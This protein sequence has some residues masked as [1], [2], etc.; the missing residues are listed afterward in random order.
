MHAKL[1]R[2]HRS[3]LRVWDAI[4]Q[5][6][7]VPFRYYGIYDGLDLRQVPWRRGQGYD[8]G[9]LTNVYTANH[10]WVGQLIAQVYERVADV[11][12]MRALGCCV[13]IEHAR[14]YGGAICHAR[15][16]FPVACGTRGTRLQRSDTRQSAVFVSGQ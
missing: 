11:G 12:S 16:Y 9:A 10:V 5:Q 3:E 2:A 15:G 13:S 1:R 14:F 7:L 6:Y 8:V 4:D